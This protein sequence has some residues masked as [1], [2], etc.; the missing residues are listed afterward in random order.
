MR[1]LVVDDEAPARERLRRLLEGLDNCSVC[2]EAATGL[3]ALGLAEEHQPDVL[4]MDIR[5]PGMDGLEAARHL[6]ALEQPPAVIFTTAY[7][8][9]ALEA[10]ETHAVDYLLKPVRRERLA[11]ALENARRLTRVQAAALQQEGRH[12]TARTRICVRVRGS[13]QLIP[14]DEIRYFQADQKYVSVAS[15]QGEL[16][17]EETLKS[18]ED[19]FRDRFIRVH[20]NALVAVRFLY[21]L[22]KDAGGKFRIQLEGVDG[23]PEVSRRHVA[24][25]RQR[26]KRLQSK[27]G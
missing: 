24:E 18:L 8:D 19:E 17:I 20:R 4:L 7:S 26:I 2:G 15:P 12:G 3:S 11:E 23:R 14:V 22:E 21:G 9:H 16:L 10:F 13:L 5:M 1:V 25:V 6:L 27:S